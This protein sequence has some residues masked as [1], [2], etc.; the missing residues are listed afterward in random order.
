VPHYRSVLAEGHT[1][2]SV[3]FHYVPAEFSGSL[4]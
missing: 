1:S 2:T 3:F 4:E